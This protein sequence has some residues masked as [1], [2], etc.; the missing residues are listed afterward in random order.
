MR[1]RNKKD[2]GTHMT[3][4]LDNYPKTYQELDA[5]FAKVFTWKGKKYQIG[6]FT[7]END[8]MVVIGSPYKKREEMCFH[9]VC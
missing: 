4:I 7:F 1:L 2:H 6:S 8:E 3:G 5:L 9:M